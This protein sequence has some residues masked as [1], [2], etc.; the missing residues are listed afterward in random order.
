MKTDFWV[1]RES[2]SG[3]FLKKYTWVGYRPYLLDVVTKRFLTD[4]L[5][6]ARVFPSKR[7]AE[8]AIPKTEIMTFYVEHLTAGPVWESPE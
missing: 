1:V 5:G 8:L 6:K 2:L 7:A 4:A 3:K